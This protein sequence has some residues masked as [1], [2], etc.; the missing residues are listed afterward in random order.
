MFLYMQPIGSVGAYDVFVAG[1]DG[2]NPRNVTNSPST[3]KQ[4]ARWGGY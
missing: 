3:F 4:C 2:S 1:A